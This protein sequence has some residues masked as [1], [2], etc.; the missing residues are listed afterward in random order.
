MRR[1]GFTLIEL[2]VVVAIIGILAAILIPIIQGAIQKSK[3]KAAMVD[4]N[5]IGQAITAFVTDTGRAPTSP[6]GPLA[7]GLKI[8]QELQPFHIAALPINDSWGHP[9]RIWTGTAVVG[10]FGIGAGVV[11]GEDFLIQSLGRDGVDEGFVFSVSNPFDLY[12]V[13][14]MSDFDKDLIVWNGAWIHA[15]R[16]AQSG[17]T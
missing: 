4:M 16:A 14:S 1:R 6:D 15:P 5:S 7:A 9:F 13:S 11:G 8:F 12:P 17:T 2:I 10:R 3:Q